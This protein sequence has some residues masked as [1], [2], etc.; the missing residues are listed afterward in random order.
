VKISHKVSSGASGYAINRSCFMGDRHRC[1]WRAA[2][3][4][5]V[6]RVIRPPPHQGNGFTV[7]DMTGYP[8]EWRIAM[9]KR[10]DD[11]GRKDVIRIGF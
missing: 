1:A 6:A 10:A 2:S 5:V 8:M 4:G 11:S 9:A 3:C 7:V